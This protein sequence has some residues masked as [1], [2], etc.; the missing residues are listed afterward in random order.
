MR[1]MIKPETDLAIYAAVLSTT[2]GILEIRKGI[3][4]VRVTCGQGVFTPSGED[5]IWVT[6]A[7]HG[8]RPVTIHNAGLMLSTGEQIIPTPSA[9]YAPSPLPKK[10][11]DGESVTIHIQGNQAR[12]VFAEM[13]RKGVTLKCAYGLDAMGKRHKGKLKFDLMDSV[14]KLAGN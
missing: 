4:K 1:P 11:E 2:L 7:N 5:M 6:V 9:M 8:H 12:N 13:R 10:L 14:L 3:K